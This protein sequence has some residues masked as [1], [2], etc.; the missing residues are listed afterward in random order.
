MITEHR[1][2]LANVVAERAKLEAERDRVIAERD[3]ALTTN[4]DTLL[5][6]T[7]QTKRAVADVEA[8]VARAGLDSG[9]R[10]RKANAAPAPRGG[11][12]VPWQPVTASTEQPEAPRLDLASA[13]LAQLRSLHDLLQHLP[14]ASPVDRALLSDQF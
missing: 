5:A 10:L 8:I 6:L 3:A 7:V 1:A 13:D 9:A 11:P 4:R 12:F 2:A 14:L